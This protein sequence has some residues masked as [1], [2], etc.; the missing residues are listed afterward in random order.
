ME[1][2]FGFLL[3]GAATAVVT[4]VAA[5]RGR[6]GWITG[7]LTVIGGAGLSMLTAA[8]G[9]GGIPAGLAAFAAPGVAL[10]AAL[11][12]SPRSDSL[13]KRCPYCAEEIRAE[14]IRCRHCGAEINDRTPCN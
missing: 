6:S 4:A 10:F 8:A 3:F 9:G 1:P 14:A 11:T 13:Y 5:K 7:L 2:I 12:A